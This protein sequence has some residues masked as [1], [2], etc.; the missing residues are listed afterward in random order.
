[1]QEP[2]RVPQIR[3]QDGMDDYSP[4]VDTPFS[5]VERW[6]NGNEHAA[7]TNGENTR[8]RSDES[9]GTYHLSSYGDM[10]C[11]GVW[12]AQQRARDRATLVGYLYSGTECNAAMLD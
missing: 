12:M 5:P 10:E 4:I 3:V 7:A 11:K 8:P 9:E 2:L 1:M 6:H